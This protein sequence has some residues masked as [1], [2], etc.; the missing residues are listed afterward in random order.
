M[1][2]EIFLGI[3]KTSVNTKPVPMAPLPVAIAWHE[4]GYW[5]LESDLTIPALNYDVLRSLLK[6]IKPHFELKDSGILLDSVLGLPKEVFPKNKTLFEL[7]QRAHRF[8]HEGRQIDL[9]T[10]QAFF[11]QFTERIPESEPI[12]DVE[13][14]GKLPSVFQ[15]HPQQKNISAGS[16]R[17]WSE[18]GS[19]AQKW[20]SMWPMD[21]LSA[22]GP[23]LFEAHPEQLWRKLV[24]SPEQDPEA[25]RNFL[26][27]QK[28]V[29]LHSSVLRSITKKEFADAV[30]LA[31]AGVLFQ[32]KKK[33][34]SASKKSKGTSL[35]KEGWI[36]GI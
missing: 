32:R 29:K 1:A 3:A 2:F 18:L 11:A 22:P 5:M 27:Q 23:W 6:D 15:T 31:C 9:K 12:R 7:M 26:L 21:D 16:F 34:F 24:K 20:F 14:L 4:D 28:V 25:L 17:F 13:R 36:L 35:K 19:S 33:L 8:S 30:L 10:A